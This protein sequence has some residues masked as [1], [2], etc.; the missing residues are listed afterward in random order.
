MCLIM[1][2][3]PCPFKMYIWFACEPNQKILTRSKQNFLFL[4]EGGN[5]HFGEHPPSK[6]TP[7]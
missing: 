1:F 6:G 3:W 2:L 7:T 5:L 4:C